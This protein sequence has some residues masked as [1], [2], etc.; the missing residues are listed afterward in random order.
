MDIELV[1]EEILQQM[2]Q[3]TSA[4]VLPLLIEHYIEESTERIDTMNNAFIERDAKTLEF[5][6]HTLGSSSL[7]LGNRELSDLARKIEHLCLKGQSEEAFEY[8]HEL[9]DIA[10][11][12]LAALAHRNTL[13]FSE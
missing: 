10:Q 11:R 5:E 7:A 12:S 4:D 3:D 13:G 6:S 2:I 1:E 9:I 8:H